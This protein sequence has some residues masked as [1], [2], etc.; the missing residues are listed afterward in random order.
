MKLTAFTLLVCGLLLQSCKNDELRYGYIRKKKVDSYGQILDLKKG[1]LLVMLHSKQNKI[2]ALHSLCKDYDADFVE[3]Q[4]MKKNKSIINTFRKNFD[5][6]PVYFFMNSQANE[7]IEKGLHAITFLNDSLQPEP[8][9]HP[10]SEI[11]FVAEFDNMQMD[12]AKYYAG[13][14]LSTQDTGAWRKPYYYS[15]STFGYQAFIIESP[16]LI[17]LKRPFPNFVTITET[18][19]KILLVESVIQ[20]INRRLTDFYGEANEQILAKRFRPYF[21]GR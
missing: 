17:Q 11:F 7:L 13:E 6:C 16:L 10:S 14:H 12:T 5:F 20:K 2:D 15:T 4:Q 21:T 18:D 1:S 3:Y 19:E 8:A 9:L